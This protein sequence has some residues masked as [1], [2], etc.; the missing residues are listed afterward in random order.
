VRDDFT[1]K[2]REHLAQRAAYRGSNPDCLLPTR[3]AD[4][5][6]DGTI[7]IG[8]CTADRSVRRELN[9]PRERKHAGEQARVE[10][11]GGINLSRFRMG[12][13]L[14]NIASRLLSTRVNVGMEV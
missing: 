3:G 2:T 7:D 9:L 14:S 12:R 1:Q 13:T 11:N 8:L 6:E 5:T 4:S 10:Q